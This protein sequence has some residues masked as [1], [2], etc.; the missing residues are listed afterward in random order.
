MRIGELAKRSGC[1]IETIRYYERIG[2][3][4]PAERSLNNYRTY[5][6]R[7]CE[8]LSFIRH[9]RALNMTL[10]EIRL[11]LDSRDNPGKECIGVNDLLDKHISHVVER[12]ATLTAL[13]GQLR[14]LRSRCVVANTTRTCAILQALGTDTLC[15]TEPVVQEMKLTE[16]ISSAPQ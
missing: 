5:S 11:L 1:L 14:H 4:E 13:E 10:G 9:C 7:H 3:L 12:I 6:D 2:L 8:R 16:V 15:M